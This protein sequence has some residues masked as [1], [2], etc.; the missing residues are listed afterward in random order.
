M[1]LD[2]RY[3]ISDPAQLRALYG[4]PRA[5]SLA[6][7]TDRLHPEHIA[8]IEASTFLV[9]ASGSEHGMDASPR[10]EASD[11]VRVADARTLLIT[12]RPGNKRLDSFMNILAQPQVSLLL[13][14]P[15][16][17]HTLSIQGR[18]RLSTDPA[19]LTVGARAPGHPEADPQSETRH[20]PEVMPNALTCTVVLEIE[21]VFFR[22]QR[23]LRQAGLCDPSRQAVGRSL[24]D[25]ADLPLRGTGTGT[26]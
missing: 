15:G 18:A 25:P 4:E 12:D 16:A 11:L 10:G 26:R 7:S 13:L 1:D 20:R 8:F 9:L 6:K 24:P 19:L 5:Q 2:P 17:T 21:Q 3:L 23:A 22:R 14:A